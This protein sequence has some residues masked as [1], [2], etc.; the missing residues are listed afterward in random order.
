M[1]SVWV[2]YDSREVAAYATACSSI[3]KYDGQLIV[4]GLVL[5]DLVEKKLYTRPTLWDKRAL[6]GPVMIDVLSKRPD[7]DGSVSTEF[8]NSRF[9]TPL[10]AGRGMALFADCDILVRSPLDEL[11]RIAENSKDKAVWCVKHNHV[12]TEHFKMDGKT[13]T[14][15]L[16]KNWSSVMLFNCDHPANKGLTM[17]M[18]NTLPGR[19]L[20]RFCW[21]DDSEIGELDPAWNFLVGHTK[22]DNPKIVHFTSGG[23]WMKGYENVPYADE[24]RAELNRWAVRGIW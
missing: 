17:D 24:W 15:Y 14:K 6:D 13:Q 22:C 12:P 3:R 8:A 21:L 11:F 10:L 5:P 19:D 9:L 2:G 1:R 20:H 7:Y 4:R 23:P 18:V 16:R